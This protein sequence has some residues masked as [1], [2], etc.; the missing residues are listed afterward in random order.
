VAGNLQPRD[1]P[2]RGAR[3]RRHYSQFVDF[4][5]RRFAGYNR[6]YPLA[7]GA[8]KFPSALRAQ[9]F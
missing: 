5:R 9:Q 3:Q 4:A 7:E 8:N 6:N 2:F 1:C